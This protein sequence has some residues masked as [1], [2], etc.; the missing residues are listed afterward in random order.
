MYMRW[1][2]DRGFKA[3][4]SRRRPGCGSTLELGALRL[5][6]AFFAWHLEGREGV[7]RY[8]VLRPA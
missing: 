3:S 4:C 8:D 6:C 5:D 2:A 7:G 1:A